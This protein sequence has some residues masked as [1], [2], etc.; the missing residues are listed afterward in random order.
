VLVGNG[1]MRLLENKE[2]VVFL[3]YCFP[4][5]IGIYLLTY[6]FDYIVKGYPTF[7]PPIILILALIPVYI[8]LGCICGKNRLTK[9]CSVGTIVHLLIC[10]ICIIYLL[11]VLN[12]SNGIAKVWFPIWCG[13]IIGCQF[14]GYWGTK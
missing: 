11:P 8:G 2:R 3:L 6:Y 9:I 14:I 13:F 4:Y 5:V 12:I 1:K 7:L 10:K